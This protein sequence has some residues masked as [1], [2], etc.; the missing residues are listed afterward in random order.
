MRIHIE[1]S[2]LPGLTCGADSDLPGARNDHGVFSM[3]RRA[4]SRFDDVDPAVLEAAVR[5]GH[6]TA[7]LRLSDAKGQPIC[8][9][10]RPP[11][12]TWSAVAPE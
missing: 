9:L 8:A 5:S 3:F 6:L 1:G 12:V 2:D 7:R 10:V 4:T 11:V